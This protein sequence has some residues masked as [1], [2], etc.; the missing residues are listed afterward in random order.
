M[1]THTKYFAVVFGKNMAD[2]VGRALDSLLGQTLSP[3]RIIVVDDGS[4][5]DTPNIL[6]RYEAQFGADSIQVIQ[7]PESAYDLRRLP[8]LWNS[9]LDAAAPYL[10]DDDYLLLGADDDV[11]ERGYAEF[12][13]EQMCADER[14]VLTS[15]NVSDWPSAPKGAAVQGGGRMHSWRFMRRVGCRYQTSYGYESQ[16]LYKA[17]QLGYKLHCFND[18]KV[19]HLR[20]LGAVHRFHEWGLGMACAG[21]L[22]LF[23]LAR[24]AMSL[25]FYSRVIPR[26]AALKMTWDYFIARLSPPKNDLAFKKW[27]DSDPAL[28][29]WLRRSQSTSA[30]SLSDHFLKAKSFF[31][32]ESRAMK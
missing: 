15:G 2:N 5:D 26:S 7:W 12:L 22:P 3:A 29:D 24:L 20:K 23:V 25:L 8:F 30:G 32:G 27:S 14:L 13:I 6:R 18:V 9:A 17:A 31:G 1:A 21:Y 10:T 11:Y 28:V 4:T 16:M 19:I